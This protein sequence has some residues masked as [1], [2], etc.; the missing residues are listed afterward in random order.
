MSVTI[1]NATSIGNNVTINM[2]SVVVRNIPDNKI[3]FGNPAREMIKPA[4][5]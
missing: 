3:M 4:S 5:N 2:G 1:A